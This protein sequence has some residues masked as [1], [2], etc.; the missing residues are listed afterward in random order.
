MSVKVASFPAASAV[1]VLLASLPAGSRV[2]NVISYG[3]AT[4]KTATVH[5]GTLAN[6]GAFAVD[7]VAGEVSGTVS[8]KVAGVLLGKVLPS[9]T[10]IYGIRGSKPTTGGTVTVAILYLDGG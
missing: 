5:I 9:P 8:S 1:Q 2:L 4:K 7:L 6:N 3:G 10:D